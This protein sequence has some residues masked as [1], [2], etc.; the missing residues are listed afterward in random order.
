MAKDQQ[1]IPW[2]VSQHVVHEQE[3]LRTDQPVIA[4][5]V[6]IARVVPMIVNIVENN[7]GRLGILKGIVAGAEGSPPGVTGGL[8]ARRPLVDVMV[9]RAVMPGDA[10][11]TE[12]F[13]IARIEG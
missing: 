7:E 10:A 3:L 4:A 11:R 5:A 1:A 12:D 9:A 2:N 13:E 6:R 8:V